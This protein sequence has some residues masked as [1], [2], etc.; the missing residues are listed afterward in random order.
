MAM[1]NKGE[2]FKY[3]LGEF[4]HMAWTR[5]GYVMLEWLVG[6]DMPMCHITLGRVPSG[7]STRCD[8]GTPV[9]NA[10]AA[11]KTQKFKDQWSNWDV[12]FVHAVKS[13]Y[14]SN[15]IKNLDFVGK[16]EELRGELKLE[17][18]KDHMWRDMRWH[19]TWS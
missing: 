17:P 10:L 3:T 18:T 4:A 13:S 11:T 2:V 6:E 5:D 1:P 8:F 12:E 14:I 7:P 9:E 16:L 15:S 19:V